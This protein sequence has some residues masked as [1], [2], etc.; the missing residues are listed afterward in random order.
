MKSQSFW[1]H[2][3]TV[4]GHTG[5]D[6]RRQGEHATRVSAKS[7]KKD[8]VNTKWGGNAKIPVE[9]GIKGSKKWTC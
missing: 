4:Q 9:K 8:L 7:L 5:K 3:L 2:C 6:Y 1:E